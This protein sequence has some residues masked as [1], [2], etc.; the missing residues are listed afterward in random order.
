MLCAECAA[1]DDAA[2]RRAPL[3]LS[4]HEV[5]SLRAACEQATAGL[6]TGRA[7]PQVRVVA[8][9]SANKM[10]ARPAAARSRCEGAA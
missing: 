9:G 6:G 2:L 5:T 10:P 1:L 8:A 7:E 4:Q 3:L